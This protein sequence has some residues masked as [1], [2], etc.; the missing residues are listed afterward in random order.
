[1]G[2][3]GLGGPYESKN[4]LVFSGLSQAL[5]TIIDSLAE[6]DVKLYGSPAYKEIRENI[7]AIS[8]AVRFIRRHLEIL[9]DRIEQIL[10]HV[11]EAEDI[12]SDASCGDIPRLLSLLS[13]IKIELNMVKSELGV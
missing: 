1:M 2:E 5:D 6:L 3:L 11:S 12:V 7:I 9:S 13:S 8:N 4:R 10:E